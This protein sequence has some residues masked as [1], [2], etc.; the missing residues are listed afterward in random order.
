MQALD[1]II[2]GILWSPFGAPQLDAHLV[3]KPKVDLEIVAW[4]MAGGEALGS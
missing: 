4:T 2:S 1:E 3:N